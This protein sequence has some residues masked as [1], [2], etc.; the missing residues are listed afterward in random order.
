MQIIK[1]NIMLNEINLYNN[2]VGNI[3]IVCMYT[4]KIILTFFK[5]YFLYFAILNN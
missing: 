4:H 3:F 5:F 2:Y 1:I